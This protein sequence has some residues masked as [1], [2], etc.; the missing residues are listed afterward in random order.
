MLKWTLGYV[1]FWITVFSG[2]MCKG[3]LSHHRSRHWIGEWA[4]SGRPLLQK[5]S[6]GEQDSW[7]R[8]RSGSKLYQRQE[9]SFRL[10]FGPLCGETEGSGE[11]LCLGLKALML[12]LS[13]YHL[14]GPCSWQVGNRGIWKHVSRR[15]WFTLGHSE[16][17]CLENSDPPGS[18][19]KTIPPPTTHTTTSQLLN[20]KHLAH[21]IQ[22]L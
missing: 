16:R 22:R 7:K 9:G 8:N 2:Y 20:K 12:A 6:W 19:T 13:L 5:K 4:L 11:T 15:K 1:S 18:W 21:V 14:S 10:L 3:L 17:A